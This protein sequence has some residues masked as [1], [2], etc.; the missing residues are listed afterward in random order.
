[1]CK[2]LRRE[3][4]HTA[5]VKKVDL[6]GNKT[7][8]L[9]IYTLYYLTKILY[10]RRYLMLN[11]PFQTKMQLFLTVI[12]SVIALFANSA[13]A[14]MALKYTW[15]ERATK[16][17]Q[18]QYVAGKQYQDTVSGAEKTEYYNQQGQ[19]IPN[20]A[21]WGLKE[22]N[23]QNN[24]GHWLASTPAAAISGVKS[25]PFTVPS[26]LL[27]KPLSPPSAALPGI[28][29]DAI[30]S[31]Q[32]IQQSR[33]NKPL[34]IG[35]RRPLPTAAASSVGKS[36]NRDWQ[37]DAQGNHYLR[38]RI[39][40]ADARAIRIYLENIKLPTGAYFMVYAT[41]N[42]SECRGPYDAMLLQERDTF[43]TESIFSTDVTLAAF[44]PAAANRANLSFAVNEIVDIFALPSLSTLKE[45]NCNKDVTCYS[46]WQNQAA[47][48]AG[49]GTINQ[50][51]AL[52][53]TG[54]LL[55]DSSEHHG[56]YFMTA[57]HCIANQKEADTTE[58]YWFYQ[59][60]ICNGSPP[61]PAN[62]PRTGGG[63]TFLAGMSGDGGNDFSF[64]QLRQAVPR[65]VKYAGW[66][67]DSPAKGAAVTGIHH[68]DG[69]YKRI[70][71][72]VLY[73]SEDN[74]WSVQWQEG[75]TEP[76]SSGSPLFNANQQ[77]VGQ[78][79]GGDSSC[80]TPYGIDA[81]GRFDLSYPIVAQW[82]TSRG[83]GSYDN[84]DCFIATAAWGSY[85]DPHV[86]V[87]R[88]F[89]DHYLVTNSTGRA[90]ME[91]YYAISPP[92]AGYI[93]Q[94]ESLR[95]ATRF[96]LTPIVY[97][98]KYPWL[99]LIFIVVAIGIWGRKKRVLE[100]FMR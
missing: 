18:T 64:L 99:L 10:F 98:V 11:R 9:H 76:G 3:Y 44:V 61:S 59:T 31:R 38:Q 47:T 96:I 81:Y 95:T 49:I 21:E 80:D 14:D 16:G 86:Q 60:S 73:G 83:G 82:L 74:W 56:N 93:R 65:T 72:G 39:T 41:Q 55:N 35:V 48:V 54:A 30:A 70:S 46:D 42:P 77:F 24:R 36:D 89:R 52:W 71:F 63:A 94:H 28:T 92:F 20:P 97:S 8:L 84:G 78:L 87:L 23:W 7:A 69:S 15:Q 79:Q 66:T 45:G 17:G 4:L 50:I 43:W 1:S 62:V 27:N 53:C 13:R 25:T 6:L 29:A 19:L 90:F 91:Y 37:T 33:P 22:K 26:F 100:K 68:P 12:V 88:N 51:G 2:T 67:S 40:V 5:P 75:V 57:Y 58:Y 32:A 85:L 34:L